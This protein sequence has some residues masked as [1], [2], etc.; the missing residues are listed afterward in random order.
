M[1][2]K[3]G[4]LVVL[5][6]APVDAAPE[7]ASALVQRRV[8]ACVNLVPAVRSFFWWEGEV[9]DEPESLLILKTRRDGFER[10]RDAVTELHPYEVPEIIATGV[11][12]ALEAYAQWVADEVSSSPP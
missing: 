3:D 2:A 4:V 10:L 7:L 9:S 8:A 11:E 12:Q 5:V 1:S 6:T